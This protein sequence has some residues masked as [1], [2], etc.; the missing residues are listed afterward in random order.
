MVSLR[1]AVARR[2]VKQLLFDCV[3]SSTKLVL[4]VY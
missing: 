3:S 2:D 4:I 1:D